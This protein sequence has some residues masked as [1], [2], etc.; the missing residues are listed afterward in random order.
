VVAIIAI[1]TIEV[2]NLLTTKIDSTITSL[3]VA[4]IAGLAG[5]QIGRKRG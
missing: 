2:V 4:A 1:A 3:V 5:Y